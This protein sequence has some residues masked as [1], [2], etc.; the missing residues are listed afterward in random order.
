[1]RGVGHAGIAAEFP[2]R[3]DL[4]LRSGNRAG[5][6]VVVPG[7]IL[8]AGVQ[9]VVDAILDRPDVVGRRQRGVDGRL[10]AVFPAQGGEPLQVDHAQVRVGGRFAEQQ[11]RGRRDGRF[12]LLEIAG[13]HDAGD[14]AEAAELV[15]AELAGPLIKLVEHHQFVAGAEPGQQQARHGRHA[16]RIQHGRLGPLENGQ[17][18]LDGLFGRVAVAG[19]F[20]AGLLL[21]D[22]VDQGLGV[23]KG[24]GRG[25]EDRIGDRPAG[26]R[27][28]SSPAWTARVDHCEL[29]PVRGFGVWGAVIPCSPV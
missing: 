12:Q 17:F 5:Q 4:L 24:V 7:K 18:P 9:H 26:F 11:P 1:M 29:G 27:L 10:D 28:L 20:L 3:L 22:E 2:Q 15:L 25:A 23:G 14:D 16:G 6:Q 8:R 13:R 19:V 21:D